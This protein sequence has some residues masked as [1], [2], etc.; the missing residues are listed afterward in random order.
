MMSTSDK[1][2]PGVNSGNA[3]APGS[4]VDL[5]RRAFLEYRSQALWNITEFERPTVEQALA[6]TR[7]LRTEGD[8]NARRLAEQIETAARAHL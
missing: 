1:I 6:I 7:Q 8:M 5:Y 3:T 2:I 4:I